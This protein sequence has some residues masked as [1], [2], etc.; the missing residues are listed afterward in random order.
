MG[1][2]REIADIDVRTEKRF[3]DRPS[4]PSQVGGALKR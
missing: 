1:T 2:E 3:R 4:L